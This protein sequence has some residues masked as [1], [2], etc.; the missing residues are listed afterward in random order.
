MTDALRNTGAALQAISGDHTIFK[1]HHMSTF[2][3][4][5]TNFSSKLSTNFITRG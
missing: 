1:Y 3:L 5:F 4:N 2:Q